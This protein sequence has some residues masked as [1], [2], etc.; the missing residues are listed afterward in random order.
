VGELGAGA[1]EAIGSGSCQG[2]VALWCAGFFWIDLYQRRAAG[3]ERSAYKSIDK[4]Y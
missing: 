1:G 3:H 4:F 2:L